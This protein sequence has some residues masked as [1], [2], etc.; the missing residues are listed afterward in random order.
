MTNFKNAEFTKSMRDTHTIYMPD[1]LHYHNEL[2]R[3]AFAYG[4][5]RLD[6]VPEYQTLT[7]STFSVI[8]KDYCTCATFIIG[9]LLT[10]IESSECEPDRIAFLEP[11]TGG[12][13]RAGNYYN[14]LID[15]LR[16]TGNA[17]IPVLSLNAHGL[18]Q[19]SGFKINAKMLFGAIAAVCYSDLLM[20]L[21][22][23]VEPYE[24]CNGETEALRQKWLRKLYVDISKGKNLFHREKTYQKIINDFGNI[25]VDRTRKKKRVGIT[26]EIYI[27]FSP[28]GNGHLEEFLKDHNCEYR[29]GG[30]INYCIYMVFSEMKSMELTDKNRIRFKKYQKI[31]DYLCCTQKEIN[32]NLANYHFLH[33]GAF[34]QLQNYANGILNEYYNIGD[35]W[36]IAGE[37]IDLIHQGYDKI[38]IVHPFGCLVS[39]VA[40]RGILKKLHQLYP[41]VSIHSIEF[42]YEQSSTL[43]E[44]R[45]LLALH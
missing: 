21:H 34:S 45:I 13:C 37:V 19:H 16:K 5:Y 3:A 43:R 35:G 40:E 18:E 29:Q 4:G 7:P 36:L 10:M 2:L 39:H 11:Q 8:N 9:N 22:Q 23:Q 15:C 25:C 32:H 30:F 17:H 20:T 33:D 26:G 41:D 42:D 6:I 24:V 12:A 28:V 31:I 27:K 14:L 1:M 38:L 44:S